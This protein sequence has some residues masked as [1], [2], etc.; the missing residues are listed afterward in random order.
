[1]SQLADKPHELGSEDS[2]EDRAERKM[3][4]S[5]SVEAAVKKTSDD[6]CNTGVWYMPIDTQLVESS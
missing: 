4:A 6:K 2:V 3:S 5:E 1:M